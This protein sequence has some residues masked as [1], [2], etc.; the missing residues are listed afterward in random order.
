EKNKMKIAVAIIVFLALAGIAW[1]MVSRTRPGVRRLT[2]DEKAILNLVREA[3]GANITHEKLLKNGPDVNL[4]IQLKNERIEE[5]N[6]NLSSLAR[7]HREGASLVAI[8][9]SLRFDD[10]TLPTPQPR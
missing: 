5:L 3:Y 10:A 6:V 2:T 9:A 4:A 1:S 7:K 8:K